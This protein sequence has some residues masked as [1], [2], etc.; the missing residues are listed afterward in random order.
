MIKVT[1]LDRIE[2]SLLDKAIFG[3]KIDT[4]KLPFS[5]D[6]KFIPFYWTGMWI[7]KEKFKQPNGKMTIVK[8]I[9]LPL[10]CDIRIYTDMK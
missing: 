4:S 7:N 10:L 3:F 9:M 5:I 2:V 8:D 6:S 1:L